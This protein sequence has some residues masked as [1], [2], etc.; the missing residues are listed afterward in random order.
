MDSLDA[1]DGFVNIHSF[2]EAGDTLE[3]SVASAAERHISDFI[4]YNIKMDLPGADAA[5]CVIHLSASP[6]LNS[7]SYKTGSFLTNP[8]AIITEQIGKHKSA[9][10]RFDM[11]QLKIVF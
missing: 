9:C 10:R 7:W 3:I 5:W 2:D 8:F 1:G 4:I 6:P 11:E